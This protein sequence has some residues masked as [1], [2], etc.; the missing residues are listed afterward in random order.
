MGRIRAVFVLIFA[1]A[2]LTAIAGALYQELGWRSDSRRWPEPGRLVN[3]LMMNCTGAGSP[4]VILESGL[5]DG[6]G[7]WRLVQPE[8]AKFTRVCS[9][10]RAGYGMSKEGP[11]PR[12]SD[13]V[14]SELHAA[15]QTAGE[16]GP[17]ILAGSSFGGYNVRV[18][19]GRYR[20]EVAGMVLVDST[21]EDQYR[22][23]PK[24]WMTKVSA[25]MLAR[26]RRQARW[27]PV[28][29]GTGIARYMLRSQGQLSETSYRILQQ[30]FV[31]TRA[32]EL[33]NIQVS[34]EQ[35]RAAG[36]F[37]DMPLIVL[38]AA[39]NRDAALRSELSAADFAEFQRVWIGDLQMRLARLS[40]RGE[41][42]MVEG[43]SHDIP[44]ERPGAIVNAVEK[45]KGRAR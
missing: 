9:Y 21:Q 20:D 32:S 18:F 23:L 43:S 36:T 31:R 7:Q 26:Y 14:A 13:R 39:A 27:A 19:A 10:D 33:E 5:G 30:K 37:G 22:L 2:V 38:T 45:V 6:S 15:L 24:A 1:A 3:G 40:S 16:K 42:V 12:T 41:R 29:I 44:S 34:A 4:T 25:E 17:F 28:F 8:I 11:M 35:A